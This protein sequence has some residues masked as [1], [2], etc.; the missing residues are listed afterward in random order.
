MDGEKRESSHE[1]TR[2]R[3]IGR[4]VL[5]HEEISPQPMSASQD[6]IAH[7]IRFI[8]TKFNGDI[9][10]PKVHRGQIAGKDHF[11]GTVLIEQHKQFLTCAVL[12]GFGR[13]VKAY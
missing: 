6:E 9:T 12:A 4:G 8:I 1:V 13:P 3:I 5:R 7:K 10:L 11:D 2:A